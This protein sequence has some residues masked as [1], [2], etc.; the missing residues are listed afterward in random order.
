MDLLMD[1]Q[2]L[3]DGYPSKWDFHLSN[4]LSVALDGKQEARQ[5]ASIACFIQKDTVPGLSAFGIRWVEYLTKEL[6]SRELDAELRTSMH[7][8][9]NSTSF[10][11]YYFIKNSRLQLSI[12]EA[13]DGGNV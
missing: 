7:D 13:E 12:Q 1:V 10:V 5:R 6:N 9:T 11:P 8:F 4:G 3:S 2:Q